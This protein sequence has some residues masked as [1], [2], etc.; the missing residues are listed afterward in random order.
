M[1]GRVCNEENN[2]KHSKNHNQDEPKYGQG[3]YLYIFNFDW[4]VT[5]GG[6]NM[7]YNRARC[8]LMKRQGP[9]SRRG[10]GTPWWEARI[11]HR[12]T[13]L[14]HQLKRNAT[15]FCK[16][17]HRFEPAGPA[18]CVFWGQKNAS[19]LGHFLCAKQQRMP[20][21]CAR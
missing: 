9:I 20:P 17:H 11:E 16:V 4:L 12:A 6:P 19:Q 8:C 13:P 10:L 7:F 1:L 21:K 5:G 2:Q 14:N 18:A 15:N 3:T